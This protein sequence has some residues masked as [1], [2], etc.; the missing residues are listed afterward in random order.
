MTTKKQSNDPPL[1]CHKATGQGY[2]HLDGRRIYLGVY[3]KPQ[4]LQKYHQVL[5]EWHANERR[6]PAPSGGDATVVELCAA[7]WDFAGQH[8]R[9][10]DG[11][12]TTTIHRVRQALRSLR[13]LYG[14][15]A[16]ADFGPLAL[17]AVRQRWIDRGLARSTIN[18]YVAQIRRAFRWGVS[19]Q[20][21]PETVYR[22][23]TTV[24]GL[25]AGRSAAKETEPRQPVPD[26][27]V[28]AVEPFVNRQ[29][30]ALIQLQLLTAARGGEV[31]ML[32]AVDF[33]TAGKSWT[34][35]LSDHKKA[36]LGKQRTVY[37]GPRAQAIV[38]GF[39]ADRPVDA[40]LF[41]PRD[42]ER[43]R[44]ARATSRRRP[45]Q[46][47]M[48]RMSRRTLGDH[49]TSASY[50]RCIERACVRA[51]VPMWTPHRLRHSAGTFIR[52]EFG[53]EA[54]QVMLGHA[55]VDVTQVYAEV[56]HAR[57]LEVASKI[58]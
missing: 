16:V 3:G 49:Y 11:V 46:Q 6:L 39:M 14:P 24:T 17:R 43:E 33:D 40:Y 12:S 54:A 50:R 25:Q 29:V 45:G 47:V 28:A 53:I 27:H 42:A 20:L 58:G 1:R 57:A 55:S 48:Q 21:V 32:R 44:H 8:Y 2:V 10:G 7:Y 41:S 31:I 56:N 37:F 15:S 23:L 38:R 9:K 4:T 36:Y 13:E 51:G 26:A 30:W 5:A 35:K 19:H 34:A 52:Q 22:A 18:D